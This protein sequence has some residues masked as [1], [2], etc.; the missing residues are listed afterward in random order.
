MTLIDWKTTIAEERKGLEDEPQPVDCYAQPIRDAF[1]RDDG[2]ERVML[3]SPYHSD[4]EKL[5]PHYRVKGTGEKED[6]AKHT[7]GP[8]FYDGEDTAASMDWEGCGYEV[9][10]RDAEGS[11][12]D[13]VCF[14]LEEED[15]RLIAAAPE[16]AKALNACVKELIAERDCFYDSIT[17]SAG[18]IIDQDDGEAL[19]EL[20]ALIDKARTAL[21]KA[22]LQ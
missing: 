3:P 5:I 11:V 12:E 21:V 8:W 7:P 18:E 4:G 15:A 9:F 2:I 17:N 22:G 13:P 19:A 1:D 16:M 10:T 6:L 20:D 14:A